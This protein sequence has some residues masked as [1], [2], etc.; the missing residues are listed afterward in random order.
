[1]CSLQFPRGFCSNVVRLLAPMKTQ[2]LDPATLDDF[3]RVSAQLPDLTA[4]AV[5]LGLHRIHSPAQSRTVS[6]SL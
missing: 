4:S 1:M 5:G 6:Q 2:N 3:G